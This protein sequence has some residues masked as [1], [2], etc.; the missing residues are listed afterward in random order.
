M[1]V[2]EI[3]TNY[4]YQIALISI[5][6]TKL[7]SK[8]LHFPFI[9]CKFYRNKEDFGFIFYHSFHIWDSLNQSSLSRF[10]HLYNITM[11]VS[12]HS[13]YVNSNVVLTL[14]A[15]LSAPCWSLIYVLRWN[16]L[17]WTICSKDASFDMKSY[18]ILLVKIFLC[19]QNAFAINCW[20]A[21]E[22]CLQHIQCCFPHRIQ[23][24][25]YKSFNSFIYKEQVAFMKVVS[26]TQ[27]SWIP[28]VIAIWSP[29]M[30]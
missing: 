28:S 30:L 14:L 12:N 19:A 26:L 22:N 1:H 6:L 29:R 3:T 8:S 13:S 16:N 23:M 11:V 10:S 7:K 21:A 9:K 18:V 24:V 27:R 20:S 2:T 25:K 17:T 5:F 4:F 15:V